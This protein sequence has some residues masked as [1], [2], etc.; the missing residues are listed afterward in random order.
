MNR[1]IRFCISLSSLQT[2]YRYSGLIVPWVWALFAVGLTY[3]LIGSLWL[4]PPDYQQGEGYRIIYVHVP[5]AILSLMCY[6]IIAALSVIYLIWRIKLADILAKVC[7][8]IG[9]CFTGLALITGSIWGKPMWGTWWIWDA[10]LTSELILLFLYFG[11]I[12]IRFAI[13]DVR[14]AGKAAGI[15]ALVGFVDI[16]IIHFSVNW[17]HTLH[18]GA[19]ITRFAKP[20]MDLSMLYPLLAMIIS[21]ILYFIA[22]ALMSARNEIISREY[23]KSWVKVIHQ[24]G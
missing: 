12:G 9:A 23:H 20:A 24:R 15:L 2:F 21:F 1:F 5:C 14:I 13:A 7:A 11:Y 4:A 6:T 19:T 3:G 22:N 10:R 18:Q 8:P 16:P 17:W